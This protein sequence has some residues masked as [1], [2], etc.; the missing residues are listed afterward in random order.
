MLSVADDRQDGPLEALRF[1]VIEADLVASHFREIIRLNASTTGLA[2]VRR[3]FQTADVLHFACHGQTNH[4]H[5]LES[6]LSV[7]RDG[8]LILRELLEF[9][10]GRHRLAL[11][12]GCETAFVS[13]SSLHRGVSLT[14]GFL[15]AGCQAVAA[16]L[17]VLPDWCSAL[18]LCR[19]LDVWAASPGSLAAALRVAQ[20]WLR[21]TSWAEKLA[22]LRANEHTQVKLQ[23]ATA[24]EALEERPSTNHPFY[25]AGYRITGS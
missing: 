7:A 3:Q 10:P 23:F 4:E 6:G 20:L 5:P 13:L 21:D 14:S 16:S 24:L 15:V 11:L 18:V 19:M 1:A 9:P 2:E 25:W 17:W 8:D 12:A 22:Y